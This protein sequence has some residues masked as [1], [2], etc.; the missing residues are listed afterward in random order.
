M[1]FLA[2][3]TFRFCLVLLRE[4]LL[5]PI[6]YVKNILILEKAVKRRVRKPVTTDTVYVEVHEWAG[7]PISRMKQLKNGRIFQC[8]LE[9][10]LGRFNM[11]KRY[12]KYKVDLTVTVSDIDNYPYD[13]KYLKGN[14]DRVLSVPNIGLDFSGYASFFQLV[15]D[16]P[17]SYVILSNSSINSSIDNFLDGYIEYLEE[18]PDVGMLGVSYCTK[19]YQTLI[20]NNFTPHLQSFFLLTTVEV[21]KELVHLNGDKFPGIDITNKQLLIRNGE[22]KLSQLIMNLGYKLAVVRPDNGE[23][24]KFTNKKAWNILK[25]DVRQTVNCP[26]RITP[27]ILKNEKIMKVIGYVSVA[28]PFEDRKAWSGTIFKIREGL[29]NA[30]YNVVWIP[31]KLGFLYRFANIL[32][33]FIYGKGPR[34]HGNFLTWI[35]AVSTSWE[36]IGTCDYLF[37]PGDC[38]ITKYRK[39]DKPIIYYSDA[40]FKQM[41]GYYWKDLSGLLLREGDRNER[42]ANDNS[43]IIIKSSH[44]AIN[45][46]VADYQQKTSKCHVLEFGANIDERD[47]VKT[48]IYHGGP[49]NILFSGVEWERKGADIAIDTVKELNRKGVEAKLFLVGIKEENIPEKYKNISCVDYIGFLNKNIPEQYQKLITIMGRCNLFLLPTKAECAGIVLCEASAFGLPIFTFDTGGIGNYVIDG[50]NGYKLTMDA[51][52][53]AFATKIKEAIE[54]NELLKL[55]EGCLNFYEEKLNWKAWAN[56]FKKLMNDA[57]L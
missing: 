35:R 15:K 14:C 32:S 11:A 44:W 48:D 41:I 39:V 12:S 10:Q 29:E 56:N 45:S 8:G 24:F 25:G 5:S 4:L 38:Q 37:F 13:M 53:N 28:N 31:I 17:N 6:L 9:Y 36:L 2:K 19:M 16:K 47:I 46:V 42:I 7:Y 27:A 55:R 1:I 43:T 33:R 21:L 23:P 40:T 50:M 52:A 57:M 22:I 30:G 49:V 3:G 20:R 26:N 54:T 51:D 18:N 34:E